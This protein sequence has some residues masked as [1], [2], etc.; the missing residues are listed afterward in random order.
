MKISSKNIPLFNILTPSERKKFFIWS[1][2]RELGEND[3]IFKVGEKRDCF[4][5]VIHGEV[6]LLNQKENIFNV[7]KDGEFLSEASLLEQGTCHTISAKTKTKT[8]LLVIS[9]D[10]FKKLSKHDSKLALKILQYICS[11][12][13]ERL[14]HADN[15]LIT[16]YRTGRI[17]SSG[18]EM[19]K[20]A[21]LILDAILEVI[22]AEQAVFGF[23]NNNK[24]KI[25]SS[26]GYL[27]KYDPQGSLVNLEQDKIFK[28]IVYQKETVILDQKGIK[29][30]QVVGK[31]SKNILWQVKTAIATPIVVSGQTIAM[32][33]LFNKQGENFNVNNQILL[34]AIADQFVASFLLREAVMEDKER[35]RL[36]RVYY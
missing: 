3:F 25:I 2:V 15:K 1:E 16:L 4:F 28:D 32:I 35:E 14:C 10:N 13:V 5:V 31:V 9:H 18:Q 22:K 26:V 20:S 34:E 17:I 12:V 6:E 7:F 23:L 27:K 33:V 29:N 21:T 24:I 8:S 11:V 30:I 19:E 36:K